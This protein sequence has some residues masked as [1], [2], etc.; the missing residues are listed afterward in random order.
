M[1]ASIYNMPLPKKL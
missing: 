1:L